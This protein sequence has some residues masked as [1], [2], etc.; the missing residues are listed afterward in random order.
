MATEVRRKIADLQPPP[1]VALVRI[2]ARPGSVTAELLIPLPARS[3]NLIARGVVV[4]VQAKQV[5]RERLKM[6]RLDPDRVPKG[7]ERLVALAE[8]LKRYPKIVMRP[9]VVRLELDCPAILKDRLVV[10]ATA[11]EH[12]AEIEKVTRVFSVLL[13]GFADK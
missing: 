5:I 10:P 8:L 13:N 7:G 2:P 1:R 3:E 9:G 6:V 12:I 4:I 11:V